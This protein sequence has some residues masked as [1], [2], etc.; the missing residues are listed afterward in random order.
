MHRFTAREQGLISASPTGPAARVC[1]LYY[2]GPTLNPRHFFSPS[3]PSSEIKHQQIKFQPYHYH[4]IAHSLCV[5][6]KGLLMGA[7]V[8]SPDT[9]A[10]RGEHERCSKRHFHGVWHRG[11]PSGTALLLARPA[12][13]DLRK[14]S[15]SSDAWNPAVPL[16]SE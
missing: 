15:G 9:G 13:L 12:G 3:E 6:G 14:L 7:H 4:F 10:G 11:Q 16:K 2:E 8:C 5:A 1:S